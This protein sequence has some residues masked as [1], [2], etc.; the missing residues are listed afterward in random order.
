MAKKMTDQ[1]RE[2]LR[3]AM[4][5]ITTEVDWFYS[6][7]IALRGQD[8]FSDDQ[9]VKKYFRKIQKQIDDRLICHAADIVETVLGWQ[10]G[11]DTP[12][13]NRY[14]NVASQIAMVNGYGHAE[15]HQMFLEACKQYLIEDF[16]HP[17]DAF[18]SRKEQ[19]S[20]RKRRRTEQK[21]GPRETVR[22]PKS[23]DEKKK[24]S[25]LR[26][27]KRKAKEEGIT[28]EEYK[29]KYG[30][31]DN[32]LKTGEAAEETSK[33]APNT[34]N[35]NAKPGVDKKASEGKRKRTKKSNESNASNDAA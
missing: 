21:H 16:E 35:K 29:K 1:Q 6:E 17:M 10:K 19:R 12:H 5:G 27:I 26:R 30:Y 13:R 20:A 15:V 22:M 31:D 34:R 4:D 18:L 32:G 8:K 3:S 23:E 2:I 11:P 33:P 14:I 28:E 25:R 24:A 7:V 9:A